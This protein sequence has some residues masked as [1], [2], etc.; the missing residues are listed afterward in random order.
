MDLGYTLGKKITKQVLLL[1]WAKKSLLTNLM[2]NKNNAANAG[3]SA[4]VSTNV[5][6]T[7]QSAL[8]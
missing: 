4:A 3:N 5:A 1:P 7:V 6:F 2:E 8:R